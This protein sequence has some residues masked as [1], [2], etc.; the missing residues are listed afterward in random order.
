[1][2]DS[3][4]R[5]NQIKRH[6]LHKRNWFRATNYYDGIIKTVAR[7]KTCQSISLP[8]KQT[9]LSRIE[10][11]LDRLRKPV[12]R[13]LQGRIPAQY[14]GS[15]CAMNLVTSVQCMLPNIHYIISAHQWTGIWRLPVPFTWQLNLNITL[16]R[17][18]TKTEVLAFQQFKQQGDNL[19][20][21]ATFQFQLRLLP[22]LFS[23]D[24]PNKCQLQ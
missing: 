17:L 5:A 11:E 16:T 7:H 23:K 14:T 9:H 13:A 24:F 18:T 20:W 2:T 3:K 15:T 21:L 4:Q 1:V 10:A 19:C 22:N 8:T 6:A 12:L